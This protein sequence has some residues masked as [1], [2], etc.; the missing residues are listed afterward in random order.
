[1]GGKEHVIST[2]DR[3]LGSIVL[4]ETSTAAFDRLGPIIAQLRSNNAFRMLLGHKA[5]F[6]DIGTRL[7][8]F[9]NLPEM[10]T[11]RNNVRCNRGFNAMYDSVTIP[12]LHNP[13]VNLK[14]KL[15]DPSQKSSRRA[16]EASGSAYSSCRYAARSP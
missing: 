11:W 3:P 1:M 7:P 9:D 16:P 12:G 4:L 6:L 15:E 14:I 8:S 13:Y 10:S 2:E 5:S